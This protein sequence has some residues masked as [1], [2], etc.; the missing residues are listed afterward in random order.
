MTDAKHTP[1]PWIVEPE[2]LWDKYIQV[3]GPYEHR[4]TFDG[5]IA[6][7]SFDDIT[8]ESEQSIMANARLI[9][10]APEMLEQ[11]QIEQEWYQAPRTPD[12]ASA[13]RAKHGIDETIA[14]H[15]WL[16]SRRAAIIAKAKGGAA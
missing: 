3:L 1:G 9:A 11:L 8:E 5:T 16:A 15:E 10:A 7:I 6:R 14:L 2:N 13:F 12:W 4:E